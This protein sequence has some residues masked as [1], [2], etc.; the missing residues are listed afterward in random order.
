M[1]RSRPRLL[2]ALLL[3]A[4]AMAPACKKKEGDPDDPT[5]GLRATPRAKNQSRTN[6]IQIGLAMHNY[7][8]ANGYLPAGFYGPDG[9]T[10]GL[11]WRVAILPFIEHDHL[12]RQFKLNEAWDSPHNKT[13]IEKMPKLFAP[14]DLDT[15]GYTYLRSFTGRGGIMFAGTGPGF[16]TQP[17]TPVRGSSI[18]AIPDGTSNTLMV[19]EAAEAVPWTKPDELELKPNSPPPKI[20]GV[21]REGL[22]VLFCDGSVRWVNG[23]IPP[24]TPRAFITKDGGEVVTFPD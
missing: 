4:L 22:H 12:Y 21:Y 19:I 24:D 8:D 6:L 18:I 23:T 1:P 17:G 7:H 3:A 5:L 15:N 16:Q 11:S 9:K 13:L 2:S 20:G 10:V 14:P